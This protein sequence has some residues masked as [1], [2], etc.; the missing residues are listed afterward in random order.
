MH[1]TPL[2]ARPSHVRLG[3]L[4]Y[5]STHPAEPR[6]LPAPSA[7]ST[8]PRAPASRPPLLHTPAPRRPRFLSGT[9]H[10]RPTPA[11]PL[12][13]P[14]RAFPPGTDRGAAGLQIRAAALPRRLTCCR[15]APPSPHS[16]SLPLPDALPSPS[17]VRG[18]LSRRPLTPLASTRTSGI[19]D[20]RGLPAPLKKS[21]ASRSKKKLKTNVATSGTIGGL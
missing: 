1:P 9:R 21:K 13:A 20:P 2:R 6:G 10:Q 14:A 5:P 18:R 15:S 11:P 16:A 12:P 17:A 19:L 4:P 8:R 3:F 7:A